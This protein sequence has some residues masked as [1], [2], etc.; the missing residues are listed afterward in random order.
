M[1]NYSL[2][3]VKVRVCVCV[4]WEC[5]KP[6]FTGQALPWMV[7]VLAGKFFVEI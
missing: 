3:T 5:V 7:E 6:T 1:E 2:W 4:L